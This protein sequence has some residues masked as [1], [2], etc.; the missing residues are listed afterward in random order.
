MKSFWNKNKV[1]F[2]R[3]DG[4]KVL[5]DIWSDQK[6]NSDF[7]RHLK[8]EYLQYGLNGSFLFNAIISSSRFRDWMPIVF[9]QD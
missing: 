3:K 9:N 7:L 2:T 6:A 8:F 1:N 5:D 4:I